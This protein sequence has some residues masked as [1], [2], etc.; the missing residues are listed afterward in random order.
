MSVPPSAVV[1]ELVDTVEKVEALARR[2]VAQLDG[3]LAADAP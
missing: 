2:V 3:T 1:A